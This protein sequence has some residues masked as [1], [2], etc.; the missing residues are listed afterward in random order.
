MLVTVS[1]FLFFCSGSA[2]VFEPLAKR[3]MRLILEEFA[4]GVKLAE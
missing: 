2:F 4:P 3:S 1:V